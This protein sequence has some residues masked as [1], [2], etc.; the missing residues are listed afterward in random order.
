MLYSTIATA[1]LF[2]A[3]AT[4][5]ALPLPPPPPPPGTPGRPGP[6]PPPRDPIYVPAG[7]L[8]NLAKLF[9]QSAL[10]SP[11]NLDLKYVVIGIGTQNYT[12]SS[13]NDSVVPGTTGAYGKKVPRSL[14]HQC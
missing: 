9:P 10:A 13:S 7:K 14:T 1:F 3:S 6:P 5:A 12:C 11:E 4:A 8:D 2:V